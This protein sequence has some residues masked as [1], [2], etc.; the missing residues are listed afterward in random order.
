MLGTILFSYTSLDFANAKLLIK[1]QKN[2]SFENDPIIDPLIGRR[3]GDFLLKEKLGEGGFGT[4]YRAEQATL[5]REAAIKILHI[6]HKDNSDKIE[7]F[8]REAKLA[9]RLE[10]PYTAHIYSFGTE[11]DG[12]MWI[13]MELIRGTTL[14]RLLKIQGPL[15]LERFVPLLEKICEVIHTAHEYGIIHR[16][17]KPANVMVISRAGRLLPKLLDFGIAKDFDRPSLKTS[18]KED[19]GNTINSTSVA[20]SEVDSAD[21]A[22]ES[23]SQVIDIQHITEN[24]P[25]VGQTNNK[26]K[27][28]TKSQAIENPT[29]INF[30]SSSTKLNSGQINNSEELTAEFSQEPQQTLGIVGSPPY[31]SSEQWL[32]N[33]VSAQ[34]DIYSLG[35]VSYEILTGHRPFIADSLIDMSLAH[36]TK[37]VP[38][39]GKD[40]P[41]A[42]D[43]V[44]AKAMAKQPIERYNTALE[45]AS[46]F[47]QASGVKEKLESLPQIDKQV[48]ETFLANA[49]QPIAQA[50]ANLATAKNLYQL[51]EELLELFRLLVH[52]LAILALASYQQTSISQ[53]KPHQSQTLIE[54]LSKLYKQD[55]AIDEWLNLTK[56][57]CSPFINH[58]DAFPIPELV[59]LFCPSNNLPDPNS[60]LF[61]PFLSTQELFRRGVIDSEEGTNLLTLKIVQMTQLL[62]SLKFLQDYRLVIAQ[63]GYSEERAGLYFKRGPVLTLSNNSF[64]PGQ[65][66]ITDNNGHP[67]LRL[68]PLVKM[69]TPFPGAVEEIFFF[70]GRNRYGGRFVAWP[71]GFELSDD[72][73]WQWINQNV[74]NLLD[75]QANSSILERTPY[76][77]LR[78]FTNSDVELF[79]GRETETSAFINRMYSQALLAVV[80][81]SGAGKS[82]FI[83]AGIIPKLSSEWLS[84]TVRPGSSPLATLTLQLTKLGL[85]E[86]LSPESIKADPELLGK[87]LRRWIIDKNQKLLLVIDQLEELFSLCLDINERQSFSLAL[88][89]AS[90]SSEE[91][92]RVILTLRDDFLIRAEQ[93]PGLRERLSGG[94]YL[95][96]TPSKEQLLRI[97]VKPAQDCGYDFE[98]QELSQEIVRDVINQPAALALLAFTAAKLWELRDR[99]FK[100]L[101]R[102]AY[103]AMGGVGGALAQHAEEMMSQMVSEEQALVRDVMRR[104]VTSEKTRAVITRLELIEVLGKERSEKVLE[105]LI[106]SRLL[107]AYEADDAI[108]RIEI[109]HEALLNAW[110]RLVKW[111]QEDMEGTRLRDQLQIAAQQ[112]E[113]RGRPKGLLWRDEALIEFELWQSRYKIKLTEKEQAFAK[114]SLAEAYRSKIRNRSLITFAL[115]I[116]T[117]G[118]TILFWQRNRIENQRSKIENQLLSFYEEQGREELLKGDKNRAL[119]YLSEAYSRGNKNQSLRFMLTQTLNQLEDKKPKLLEGHSGQVKAV[120]FSPDS[121]MLASA[122][123]DRSIIIWDTLTG[124]I[125][126]KLTGHQGGVNSVAFSFDGKRLISGSNDQTIKIWET[127]SGELLDTIKTENLINS[128]AF[129]PNSNQFAAASYDSTAKIYDSIT[130]QPVLSLSGHKGII[131]TIAYSPD[132]KKVITASQDQT[133]K[134][135][136]ASDGKLLETLLSHQDILTS[137][138]FSPNNKY[139]LTTSNDHKLKTWQADTAKLIDT[140]EI[141]DQQVYFGDFSSDS[142]QIVAVGHNQQV[143]ILEA[144]S[145]RQLFAF[146]EHKS[147]VKMAKYSPNGQYLATASYD[148]TVQLLDLSLDNRT[149]TEIATLVESKIPLKLIDEHIVSSVL[150]TPIN[151]DNTTS[152]TNTSDTT[153]ST[154]SKTLISSEAKP[155]VLEKFQFETVNTD[156][157][158]KIIARRNMQAELFREDLGNGVFLDMV[159]I[160]AGSFIIGSPEG[161]GSPEEKPQLQVSIKPFFIGKLEIT[162]DVWQRVMGFNPSFSKGDNLPVEMVNWSDAML[163]CERLSQLTGRSYRL[164][165]ES[166]WEYACRAGTTT[167]FAFGENILPDIANYDG[168]API[169]Q[170]PKGIFREKSIPSGSLGVANNY[171]LYDMHGNIYEWCL[172]VGA[173]SYE[174][175]PLDG[176]SKETPYNN[177]RVL[178][179]GSWY[180]P[181]LDVRSAARASTQFTAR[182][183]SVGFRVVYQP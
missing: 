183:K 105:K 61:E 24:Q 45:F 28:D 30:L 92:I 181:A 69:A 1:Y 114:A 175:L 13:A 41:N 117:L 38:A 98:D 17:I 115:L 168:S 5:G 18:L 57:L 108:E 118:S 132:G 67:I 164:P 37:P 78:A 90:S 112:W 103:L 40:F 122:S 171:G 87:V 54:L 55:L 79:Y 25:L 84:I 167:Q 77:G 82:S 180:Y 165:T 21:I 109:I 136:Q 151:T 19:I 161:Q 53:T 8:K 50:I 141:D 4:V 169:E 26:I 173:D 172:D 15:P 146:K 137:A 96:A 39:L 111:Q 166:E 107:V 126:H 14:D 72:E 71:S 36:L 49:P 153:T 52:Y 158:G 179:G 7:R 176:S 110:P 135:W 130:K 139:I 113:T 162:Q 62:T 133:A 163:F 91:P 120:A 155:L 16:D 94:L 97:L 3:L 147:I 63:E 134:I 123:A 48:Q 145:D 144:T 33:P 178:R 66:I 93:L 73:P 35:V 101:R 34:S 149:T 42:L 127:K 74:F 58:P 124:N 44:I 156:K 65:A 160:P 85:T 27:I 20:N 10:H 46:A 11:K 142:R 100:Q 29:A 174:G 150:S 95:L 121:T 182:L 31:M 125:I 9:S 86:S 99:Q 22:T 6:R 143:K 64:K 32:N 89:Q 140:F 116:L 159:S 119:I 70:I 170:A 138:C 102:K 81:P 129:S 47:R 2:M 157:F 177:S 152:T 128:V 75:N 88:A 104:L 56:E 68:S 106:A 23:L 148:K 83:Q 154:Y 51:R 43:Q 76:V 80:G 131:S 60:K 12:L 59:S